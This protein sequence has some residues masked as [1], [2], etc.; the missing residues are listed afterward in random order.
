[1]HVERD[2]DDVWIG[3]EVAVCIEGTVAL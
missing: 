3:G 1:V 2:G